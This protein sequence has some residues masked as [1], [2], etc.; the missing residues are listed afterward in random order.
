[1]IFRKNKV[2]ASPQE[3]MWSFWGRGVGAVLARGRGV[4]RGDLFI[5][6]LEQ[7]FLVLVFVSSVQSV[8]DEII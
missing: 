6:G 3:N 2:R 4:G 7:R 5:Q 8:H 1:M